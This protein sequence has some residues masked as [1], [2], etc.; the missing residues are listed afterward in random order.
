MIIT[1]KE[2]KEYLNTLP[3]D[4]IVGCIEI[5]N[6]NDEY[7]YRFVRLNILECCDFVPKNENL[8][9]DYNLL[10]IGKEWW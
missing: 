8:K 3:D 4:T 2:F 10:R 6:G 7:D 1:V 5:I 9:N